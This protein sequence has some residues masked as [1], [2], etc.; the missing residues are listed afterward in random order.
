M[1]MLV[2]TASDATQPANSPR[3]CAP[4]R[5]RA[6]DLLQK[7][8]WQHEWY[9]CAKTCVRQNNVMVIS[10]EQSQIRVAKV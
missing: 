2:A 7:E 4:V 9:L 5:R 6:L 1:A 3:F 10:S 8:L